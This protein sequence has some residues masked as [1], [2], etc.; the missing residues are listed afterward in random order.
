VIVT[1][2]QPTTTTT[3]VPALPTPR[4]GSAWI[5]PGPDC[6]EQVQVGWQVQYSNGETRSGTETF[7]VT[8]QRQFRIDPVY[9]GTAVIDFTKSELCN[10]IAVLLVGW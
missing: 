7:T 3:Q 5:V 10:L 9:P 1:P 6:R 8:E 2:V 4:N